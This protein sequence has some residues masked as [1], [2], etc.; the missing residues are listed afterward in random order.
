MIKDI[1]KDLIYI[2]LQKLT[3]YCKF[4][5]ALDPLEDL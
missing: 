3:V 2:S 1:E 5:L 4:G